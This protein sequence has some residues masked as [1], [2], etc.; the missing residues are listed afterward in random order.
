M[1]KLLREPCKRTGQGFKNYLT[2]PYKTVK[3]DHYDSLPILTIN[4]LFD[5]VYQLPGVLNHC[6]VFGHQQTTVVF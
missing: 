3:K 1:L 2:Q 4:F 5:Q 6:L